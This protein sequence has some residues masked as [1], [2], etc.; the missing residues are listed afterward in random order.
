MGVLGFREVWNHIALEP[1]WLARCWRW[2][3][4]RQLLGR[5]FL[6]H[7]SRVAPELL[8]SVSPRGHVL[9]QPSQG[10]LLQR[11]WAFRG[12]HYSP[13]VIL[14]VL[15]SDF[16]IRCLVRL[17]RIMDIALQKSWQHV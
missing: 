7:P 13:G 8:L 6:D 10:A 3:W 16:G 14:A 2:F 15:M 1:V 5:Q 11:P 17:V 9:L 4:G 12:V